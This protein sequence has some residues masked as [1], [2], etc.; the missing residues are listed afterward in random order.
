MS[1]EFTGR[2]SPSQLASALQTYGNTSLEQNN[3]VSMPQNQVK[4]EQGFPDS[5]WTSWAG[6]NSYNPNADIGGNIAVQGLAYAQQHPEYAKQA[7][8]YGLNTWFGGNEPNFMPWAPK[9]W[10]DYSDA[11]KIAYMG[12]TIPQYANNNMILQ[13]QEN[14]RFDTGD[15]ND[16]IGNAAESSAFWADTAYDPNVK[17]GINNPTYAQT[18]VNRYDQPAEQKLGSTGNQTGEAERVA[19]LNDVQNGGMGGNFLG[20]VDFSGYKPSQPAKVDMSGYAF[21]GRPT[22]P[23]TPAQP[24]S[25]RNSVRTALSNPVVKDAAIF[26]SNLLLPGAGKMFGYNAAPTYSVDP[27]TTFGE[28]AAHAADNFVRNLPVIGTPYAFVTDVIR[29][30]QANTDP[31]S[32]AGMQ[33]NFNNWAKTVP[34]GNGMDMADPSYL[35]NQQ[36]AKAMADKGIGSSYAFTRGQ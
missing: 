4:S 31:W 1:Y 6:G 33:S 12:Q 3:P 17:T 24:E 10:G 21:T 27:N 23:Q 22:A 18:F 28:K 34:Y 35:Q 13:Q 25:F 20:D 15:W 11:E 8:D 32:S 26:G 5:A 16:P 29:Q 7:I 19:Q 9:Q 14:S 36:L 30:H 2:S